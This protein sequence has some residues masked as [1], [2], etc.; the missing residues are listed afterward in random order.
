MASEA[1][2][3]EYWLDRNFLSSSR[4][5]YQHDLL[6]KRL[7]YL[8]HPDICEKTGLTSTSGS[9]HTKPIRVLDLGCGN[10]IWAIELAHQ[11]RNA[12]C[13][14]Q[15]TGLD[16]SPEMFPDPNTWPSN[17]IFS[18]YNFM[19]PPPEEFVEK[20]DI[21]NN[22]FIW[23]VLWRS[24]EIRDLVIKHFTRMLKPG[25]Y[26]QWLEPMPPSFRLLTFEPDGSVSIAEEMDETHAMLERHIPIQTRSQWLCHLDKALEQTGGYVD[27]K[28]EPVPFRRD[29]VT[30]DNI[31]IR[32]NY[33][34]G[35]PNLLKSLPEGDMRTEIKEGFEQLAKD[36]DQ[37]KIAYSSHY[38]VTTARKRG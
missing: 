9:F 5:T 13:P 10:G 24:D 30:Y 31:L 33:S 21:I 6:S 7:G 32:W 17:V 3:Q 1:D 37:G 25:G 26:L 2:Q 29:L 38:A 18:T 28:L 34:E 19:K 35:M 23:P 36:L 15:I 4:L 22:R 8:L 12:S 14:V 20:F 11:L 16:I 27:A